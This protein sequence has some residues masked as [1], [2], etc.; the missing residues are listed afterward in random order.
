MKLRRAMGVCVLLLIGAGSYAAFNWDALQTKLAVHRFQSATADERPAKAEALLA[1]PEGARIILELSFEDPALRAAAIPALGKHFESCS[2]S[3]AAELG[4]LWLERFNT[5]EE[6]RDAQAVLLP[7]IVQKVGAAQSERC[8]AAVTAALKLPSVPARLAA[9]RA[10]IHPEIG[11]RSE[12]VP[13][14]A[15]SEAEV[16]RAALFAVGPASDAEPVLSDED[17]FHWLHDSDGGVRS[18]CRDALVSR[19]RSENE[20]AL[21]GRLVSP[22]AGERLKLLLDLRYEEDLA[23][24]EPWLERLS[25]DADPGVRAGAVRVMME[26]ASDR[27]AS[28]PAWVNQMAV[29]DPSPLV[30]RIAKFYQT[31]PRLDPGLQLVEG[32]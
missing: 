26:I 19:G 32:P 29:S 20:I 18:I 14:L 5:Q 6:D 30:R 23:D 17:L 13:L 16:R 8:R 21:G 2:A 22:D 28:P 3:E 11:L 7:L 12:I 27:K 9:I 1:R 15:C 10:A 25:H 24:P 4:S 31:S